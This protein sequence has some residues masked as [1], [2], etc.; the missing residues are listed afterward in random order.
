MKK[1]WL[2]IE[3]MGYTYGSNPDID[4]DLRSAAHFRI[5]AACCFIMAP[6][7]GL[8]VL[9]VGALIFLAS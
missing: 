2:L 7:S 1:P 4:R 3:P 9:L 5:A 6:V 8:A